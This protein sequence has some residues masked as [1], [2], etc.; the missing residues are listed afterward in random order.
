M[1]TGVNKERAARTDERRPA[2]VRHEMA[3]LDGKVVR[4]GEVPTS[5]Y[6]VGSEHSFDEIPLRRRTVSAVESV[7]EAAPAAA[8]GKGAVTAV[9]RRWL[10]LPKGSDGDGWM[11]D[12]P[13]VY[14]RSKL[15]DVGTF[16][17]HRSSL[18]WHD[19]LGRRKSTR[20]FVRRTVRPSVRL[21]IRPFCQA[22]DRASARLSIFSSV[23][24]GG[25]VAPRGGLA[26]DIREPPPMR[27]RS[28]VAGS[29][30]T[31]TIA[32]ARQVPSTSPLRPR[33]AV[34]LRRRRSG[35]RN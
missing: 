32:I 27:C 29:R 6:C 30:V 20:P 28:T 12:R 17:I 3:G 25:T 11:T 1:S 5:G 35:I 18:R 7:A 21:S 26:T 9:Y 24:G 23:G 2:S 16:G 33:A 8:G 10:R 14:T 34:G 15:D 31:A 22:V 19:G 4:E 13:L